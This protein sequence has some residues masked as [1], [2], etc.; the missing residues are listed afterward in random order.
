MFWIK[1]TLKSIYFS[2]FESHLYYT[3]LVWTQNFNSV[4]RLHLLQKKSFRIMF[5][6]G[7]N[8]FTGPYFMT[9][10]KSLKWLF[11]HPSS[12]PDSNF[13]FSLTLMVQNGQILFTSKYLLTVL[14]SSLID[15]DWLQ[16]QYIFGITHKVVIK[17]SNFVIWEQTNWKIVVTFL[18][19]RYK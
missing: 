1:K 19:V 12:I 10:S 11:C 16:M 18:L 15:V 7:R 5:F 6:Q 8:Y 14:K 4:K 13:L 9:I 2:I 3:S 17:I